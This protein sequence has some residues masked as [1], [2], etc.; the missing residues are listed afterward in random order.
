[1]AYH[2]PQIVI[3]CKKYYFGQHLIYQWSSVNSSKVMMFVMWELWTNYLT[4]DL[5][6]FNIASIYLCEVF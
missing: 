2:R 6:M 5:S 3:V 1:M 4:P